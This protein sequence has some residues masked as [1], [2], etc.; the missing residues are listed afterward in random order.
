MNLTDEQ[1]LKEYVDNYKVGRL[2]TIPVIW[3]EQLGLDTKHAAD[4]LNCDARAVRA[5]ILLQ[6]LA[7]QKGDR[8]E[9]L[10]IFRD[11]RDAIE[12]REMLIRPRPQIQ[13]SNLCQE[14]MIGQPGECVLGT[15]VCWNC[16]A[17]VMA[18]QVSD[19]DGHCPKCGAE[20]ANED[21]ED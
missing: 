8:R 15:I 7:D 19:N 4:A 1:L 20:H 13:M 14:I 12:F 9:K 10:P 5:Q 3:L 17:R 6:L 16:K 2:V 18:D 11:F 21:D